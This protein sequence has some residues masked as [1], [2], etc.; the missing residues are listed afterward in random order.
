MRRCAKHLSPSS[1]GSKYTCV[2]NKVQLQQV[3]FLS[4]SFCTYCQGQDLP[5]AL[6]QS[7]CLLTR[8]L[9]LRG[10]MCIRPWE[11]MSS[12]PMW[13]PSLSFWHSSYIHIPLLPHFVLH[14]KLMKA[15]HEL[16]P[17]G[18]NTNSKVA[19]NNTFK[20]YLLYIY[21]YTLLLRVEGEAVWMQFPG[22]WGSPTAMQN[23]QASSF[24]Q[25]Q[26]EDL[27]LVLISFILSAQNSWADTED[28]LNKIYHLMP[29]SC[30]AAYL[31]NLF[32][33]LTFC[34]TFWQDMKSTLVA[35]IHV[36]N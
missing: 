15:Q 28:T 4:H 19:G 8:L 2:F 10:K 21:I 12:F 17:P 3:C 31:Q 32:S 13:Q 6:V 7:L 20:I 24:I 16:T 14:S 36:E 30:N 11:R 23:Y 9:Q 26:V 5:A 33:F 18:C 25:V 27:K 35:L 22:P 1:D 34:F 29:G